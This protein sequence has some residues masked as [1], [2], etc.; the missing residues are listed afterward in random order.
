MA[1]TK[2]GWDFPTVGGDTDT[3]GGKLNDMF[4]DMDGDV[5]AIKTTADAALPRTGGSLTGLVTS[6]SVTEGD[7]SGSIA[8]DIADGAMHHVTL[9]GNA[10]ITFSLSADTGSFTSFILRL[11]N[12]GGY[13][14]AF[15][16]PTGTDVLWNLGVDPNLTVAG[17]DVLGFLA[18]RE[19]G[20]SWVI[21]GVHLSKDSK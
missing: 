11:T 6:P 5:D 15:K 18:H 2:F 14:V 4:E 7:T 19:T 16:G 10:T 20:G 13:T 8:I 1:T 17:V 3:W 12:A 9:T 21:D